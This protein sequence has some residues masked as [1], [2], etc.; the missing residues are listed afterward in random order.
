MCPNK[1]METGIVPDSLKLAKVIPIHKSKKYDDFTNYRPIALLTSLS[2]ILEK[3]VHKRLYKFLEQNCILNDNQ[4]GF[5]Q[6]CGTIDAVTKFVSAIAQSLDKKEST[7]AVYL[8][9]SKAFDT[10][11]HNLLL[12]KLNFYGIRGIPLNWF[13]SYLRQRRQYVEYMKYKSEICQVECGV[14]QGSVLGPLLFLLYINDLPDAI[15]HAQSILF[16]DDTTIYISG[17]T[18]ENLYITMNNE[19]SKLADWYR[20]N[21]LSLNETKTNFMIF[22]NNI[23]PDIN[24][25][26]TINDTVVN[27][28][29]NVKFL[30]IVIDNKLKW[31]E[32]TR[33]TNQKISRAY[34]A[35]TK[36]RYC[37]PKSHLKMLYH[38]IIYPHLIY[39]ITIWGSAHDTH[40]YKLRITQKKIIRL[41]SGSRYD[42]PS[43]PI[44]KSQQILKLDDIYKTYAAQYIFRFFTH[45]LPKPLT[46]LF[47]LVSDTHSY[48]TRHNTIHKLRLWRARTTTTSQNI[49]TTGPHI[50]NMLPDRIYLN[51][52]TQIRN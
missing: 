13:E 7:L 30:G 2:K 10:L 40:K 18:I 36:A 25:E 33:V 28:V 47:I 45:Y 3:L 23:I 35:L 9:L 5:R 37:L 15:E 6:N 4:Y 24:L 21:K 49:I 38:S 19:L 48:A 32:H 31:N 26:I 17:K 1:S 14:P 39:G 44:F 50:W 22:T 34:Y 43:E 12:K 20:A 52:I 8:D 11:D 16:A 41:I 42:A 29:P 27:D 51:G 46:T